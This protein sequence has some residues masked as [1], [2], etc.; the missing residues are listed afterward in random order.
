MSHLPERKE[1]I[2]L[3]CNA[4]IHGRYCHVCGQENLEPREPFWVLAT[5]FIYD[6]THFDGKFFSILK[7]LLFKPGF[8]SREYLKGRRAS[9]LHPIRL[10]VFTSAVFFLVFFSFYQKGNVAHADETIR[11]ITVEIKQLEAKR[12]LYTAEITHPDAADSKLT[13]EDHKNELDQLN[14]DI[15]VL[16]KDSTKRDSVPS[17]AGNF[18]FFGSG[19]GRSK[20]KSVREYDSVQHSMPPFKRDGFFKKRII[21]Q[22]L[23][24]REK[25]KN[26][27][28]EI[29]RAVSEK[30]IHLFPQ[31][32]FVSLPLFALILQILYVR[33]K[34]F[35]YVNH[36]VYALHLYCA[37]F[38]LILVSLLT[39]SVLTYL[40]S[41][42]QILGGVFFMVIIFYWYKSLRNFYG[43]SR[44]K[45]VLKYLLLLFSTLLMMIFLFVLFL[46]FTTFVI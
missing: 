8:L 46:L 7:W 2:C 25:Y 34:Q 9:Y 19:N 31:M 23:H 41:S 24:L 17:L 43:Q 37:T 36:V 28:S 10:Y 4:A 12:D 20:A 11:P 45:T 16:K 14:R 26:N 13:L 42:K 1:K 6:I 30:F 21:R 39:G 40:H 22:E 15:A 35:Y 3:N 44:K 33:R 27:G 18:S 5:H 38:I 29:V 32:L